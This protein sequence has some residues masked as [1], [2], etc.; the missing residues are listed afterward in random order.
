MT[1]SIPRKEIEDLL[2][3]LNLTIAHSAIIGLLT[4]DREKKAYVIGSISAYEMV[5]AKLDQLLGNPEKWDKMVEESKREGR[6]T[7]QV[8][9]DFL[10]EEEPV[11]RD[12]G[13][14]LGGP[15]IDPIRSINEETLALKFDI[16]G[17]PGE[18]K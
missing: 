9:K 8:V 11:E 5:V 15:L 3:G 12:C 14:T 10:K 16:L 4:Q 18:D 6:T 7:Q 2:I 13:V 17:I 1:D